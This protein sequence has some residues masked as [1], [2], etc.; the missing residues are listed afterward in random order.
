MLGYGAILSG[1]SRSSATFSHHVTAC[2]K[3]IR[4]I[5]LHTRNLF[6][7]KKLNLDYSATFSGISR[8]SAIFVYIT[9]T[10]EA[11]SSAIFYMWRHEVIDPSSM[12]VYITWLWRHVLPNV[13]HSLLA[14]TKR[15]PTWKTSEKSPV[16]Y[17]SVH[18]KTCS[19]LRTLWRGTSPESKGTTRRHNCNSHKVC[20]PRLGYQK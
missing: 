18:V 15:W 14:F 1:I 3:V 12:I 10:P 4:H 11:R 16:I 19:F 13:Q 9:W 20:V 17:L 5:C 7:Y 2:G 6:T 8:S